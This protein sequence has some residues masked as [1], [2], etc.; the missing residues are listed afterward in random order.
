MIE[1]AELIRLVQAERGREIERAR[2]ARIAVCAR[3]CCR[4]SGGADRLL[5]A[6]RPTPQAC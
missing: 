2:W 4:A 3:A 1:N 6:I 5:R